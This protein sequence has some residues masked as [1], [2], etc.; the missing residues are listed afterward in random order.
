MSDGSDADELREAHRKLLVTAAQDPEKV[1]QLEHGPPQIEVWKDNRILLGVSCGLA[2]ARRTAFETAL[3]NSGAKIVKYKT[4]SGNGTAKEEAKLVD[5]CDIFV[6]RYREGDAY[7]RVCVLLL[8]ALPDLILSS[9]SP[10]GQDHWFNNMDVLR[11]SHW[12]SFIPSRSAPPLPRFQRSSPGHFDP[13]RGGPPSK[14]V[15]PG[16]TFHGD[17]ESL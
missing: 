6:T 17:S 15:Y 13:R 3:V 9:G 7:A 8:H 1:N 14:G 4:N 12:F 16:N 2:G 11:P 5:K 10:Q